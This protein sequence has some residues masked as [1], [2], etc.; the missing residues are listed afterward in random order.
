MSNRGTST[1]QSTSYS[2]YMD[3]AG[4]HQSQQT[5]TN[6]SGTSTQ[7]IT[8]Q[9]GQPAVTETTRNPTNGSAA[10]EVEGLNA[11]GRIEDVSE[12]DKRYEEAIEEE[13]AKREGGA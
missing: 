3:S 10:R 13:Y 8:Q 9:A 7:R 4:N 1:F 6:P 11:R 12:A 2:S 5:S